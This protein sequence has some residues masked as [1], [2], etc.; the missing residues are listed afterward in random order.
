MDYPDLTIESTNAS[1]I[2]YKIILNTWMSGDDE[3]VFDKPIFSKGL[4]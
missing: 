1:W 2:D 4:G 3:I